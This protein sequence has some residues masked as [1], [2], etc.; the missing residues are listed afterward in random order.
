MNCK[1]VRTRLVALQDDE[2]GDSEKARLVSHLESCTGCQQER[3]RLTRLSKE[4]SLVGDIPA[5]PYFATRLKQRIA[6]RQGSVGRSPLLAWLRRAAIPA[7]V[8]ATVLITGLVGSSLGR[9]ISGGA[10]SSDA[11]PSAASSSYSGSL[12]MDD[13]PEGPLGHVYSDFYAGGTNG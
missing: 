10:G 7:G 1:R 3:E 12:L 8:A 4:L 6:D 13:S 5:R 11:S 9:A 2:V